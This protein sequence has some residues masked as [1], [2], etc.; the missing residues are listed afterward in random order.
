[1][2]EKNDEI[3]TVIIEF[4]ENSDRLNPPTEIVAVR[5]FL[6]PCVYTVVSLVGCVIAPA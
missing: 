6:P 3:S 5:G 2:C 1:M 4:Q